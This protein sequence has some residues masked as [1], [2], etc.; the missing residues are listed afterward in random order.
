[1]PTYNG[2]RA[3]RALLDRQ[4]E[5]AKQQTAQQAELGQTAADAEAKRQQNAQGVAAGYQ[6]QATQ[7]QAGIQTQRDATQFGYQQQQN[8]QQAQIQ[9][10]RDKLL[11]QNQQQRDAEARQQEARMQEGHIQGQMQIYNNQLSQGEILRLQRMKQGLS[12]TD[13]AVQNGTLTPEEGQQMRLQLQSGIDPLQRR[14]VQANIHN[15]QARTQAVQQQTTQQ[16]TEF[17]RR[18][19][20]LAQSAQDRMH[21]VQDPVTGLHHVMQM[22]AN[23]ELIPLEMSSVGEG[24][25][26]Q[27]HGRGLANQ[28]A[29][30]NLTH[31]AATNPL[32]LQLLQQEV[33]NNPENAA[34]RQE[35]QRALID[36]SRATTGHLRAMEPGELERQRLQNQG[37]DFHNANVAPAELEGTRLR[38]T[39]INLQN[40]TIAQNLNQNASMFPAHLRSAYAAATHSEQQAITATA[41][42]AVAPELAQLRVDLERGHITQLEYNI[43]HQRLVNHG[44]EVSL[45]GNLTPQERRD[46]ER[47]HRANVEREYRDYNTAMNTWRAHGSRPENQPAMPDW[48]NAWW[49]REDARGNRVGRLDVGDPGHAEHAINE[50]VRARVTAQA[51]SRRAETRGA[52]V[53]PAVVLPR[54]QVPNIPAPQGPPQGPPNMPQG[55]QPMGAAPQGQPAQP[56]APDARMYVNPEEGR[57]IPGETPAQRAARVAGAAP[58]EPQPTRASSVEPTSRFERNRQAAIED[59]RRTPAEINFADGSTHTIRRDEAVRRAENAQ[60]LTQEQRTSLMS[61]LEAI[62][63]HAYE[64]PALSVEQRTSVRKDVETVSDLIKQ[65]GAPD[66]M[67]RTVRSQFDTAIRSIRD[68]GHDHEL[69]GRRTEVFNRSIA[70]QLAIINRNQPN[71][72]GG[73]IGGIADATAAR[74]HEIAQ[75]QTHRRQIERLEALSRNENITDA[76]R[77]EVLEFLRR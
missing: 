68:A 49:H 5:I 21:M 7:Q 52:D 9:Q 48:L 73:L 57:F 33:Q 53:P 69:W 66:V 32:H 18:Q 13:E 27:L 30:Q 58:R 74:R 37:L 44:L 23:G 15:E 65:F 46:A 4:A 43:N 64:S 72:Q 59:A 67:P 25:L 42:A 17:N 54:G 29:Q 55:G 28:Q 75:A 34:L 22:S 14:L 62:G 8:T 26:M 2:A 12:S 61:T 6:Q 60:P 77:R 35:Y 16:A 63:N 20:I 50:A 31:T 76:E 56:S 70:A 38:N 24:H 41:N 40:S 1:M 39:G 45:N 19:S 51:A 47:G 71:G 36:H 11:I 3:Q 10:E